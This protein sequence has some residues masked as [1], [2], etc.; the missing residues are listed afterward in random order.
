MSDL[1]TK[2]EEGVR[3]ALGLCRFRLGRLGLPV[4]QA[5]DAV[6]WVLVAQ[7]GEGQAPMVFRSDTMAVADI[8]SFLQVAVHHVDSAEATDERISQQWSKKAMDE[9]VGRVDND[10]NFL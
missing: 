6:R 4:W 5:D 8:A 9:I 10:L 7:N 1:L 3:G 2:I